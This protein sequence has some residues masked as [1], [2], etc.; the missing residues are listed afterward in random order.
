MKNFILLLLSFLTLFGCK[1]PEIETPLPEVE[2]ILHISHTRDD[3]Q[4]VIHPKLRE[5]PLANY[6]MHLLG[7]D[8]DVFTSADTENMQNWD[9]LFDFSAL[10]TLWTLGNHDVNNRDLIEDFTER[11]SFYTYTDYDITFLVLDTD[12]DLSR[13]TGEQLEMLE[14]VTDTI[15]E[16]KN[17]VVLT[18]KLL[19]LQGNE[20]VEP[21]LETVPNGGPGDCGYCTN[22][23]NFY[24]DVYPHLVDVQNR[25]VQVWCIAGDIGKKTSEFD[26]ILPEGVRLL[27]SGLNITAEENKILELVRTFGEEDWSIQYKSLEEL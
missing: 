13:I 25:G 26:Y 21:F 15:S 3:I 6:K 5:I 12:L 7:G 27:A 22:P 16:S 9:D 8:M 2:K 23:N 18:H 11:P 14:T 1:K 24:E 19:W 10:T 17:L 20:A 4:G